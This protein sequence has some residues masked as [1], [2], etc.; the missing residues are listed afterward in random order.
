M[1][2]LKE[3]ILFFDFLENYYVSKDEVSNNHLNVIKKSNFIKEDKTIVR[4]SHPPLETILVKC[5]RTEV[6]TSSFKIVDEQI[7]IHSIIE[8]K[9]KLLINPCMFL[10]NSLTILKKILLKKLLLQNLRNL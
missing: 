7:P 2:Q 8:Q 6:K 4:L 3:H 9:K 10:V 5:K 1:N